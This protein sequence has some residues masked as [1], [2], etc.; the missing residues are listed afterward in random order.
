MKSTLQALV[1][2]IIISGCAD[3]VAPMVSIPLTFNEI[4]PAQ[5]GP[6]LVVLS[7]SRSVRIA[8]NYLGLACGRI[9]A[10]AQGVEDILR[11]SIKPQARICDLITR[12]YS[13]ELVL[14]G[15]EPGTYVVEVD[16]T[17][18]TESPKVR[19]D[20]AIVQL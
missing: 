11:V 6:V 19:R 16:H 10:S 3:S 4:T 1:A 13:Y 5:N 18:A 14:I 7:E 20:T 17:N 2:V 12:A 15:L 8:G 9:G